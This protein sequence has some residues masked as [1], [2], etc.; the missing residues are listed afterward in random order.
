MPSGILNLALGLA[1]QVGQPGPSE[2]PNFPPPARAFSQHGFEGSSEQRHPFD[3]Q[4]NW[5]H[6]YSQEIPAYGGHPVGRPYNYKDVLSQ[7]QTF[8]GWGERPAM[9]YSHQFWHKYQDQ[10]MMLKASRYQPTQSQWSMTQNAV[11]HGQQWVAQPTGLQMPVQ[12]PVWTGS[13][14]PANSSG[15]I[16]PSNGNEQMQPPAL[17]PVSEFNQINYRR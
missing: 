17:P 14:M 7:S 8:G 2:A 4:M 12:Q 15:M 11:S 13:A 10:S 16:L 5:V 9:P 3:S 1:M 6:G